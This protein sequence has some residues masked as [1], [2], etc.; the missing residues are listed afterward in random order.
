MSAPMININWCWTR[1]ML[2]LCAK[3]S[4]VALSDRQAQM[5]HGDV[6]MTLHYTHSDLN[7]RRQAIEA[8]KDRLMGEAVSVVN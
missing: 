2:K 5:G 3:P 7:R 6:R 1:R 4:T 8:M